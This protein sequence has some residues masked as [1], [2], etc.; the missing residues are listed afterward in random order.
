VPLADQPFAWFRS[1]KKKWE[2]RR[3]GRQYTQR[4]VRVGRRVELRRGY[5]GP[6]VLWGEILAVIEANGI[7]DFFEKVDFKDVVPVADSR[8][9][10][11]RI[12]TEILRIDSTT[13]LLG[14][15]VGHL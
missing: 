14:F 5:R 13:P 10:A 3:L 4:H 1:G 15:A 7:E 6:D 9:D 12:A 8:E 11:V 2:L